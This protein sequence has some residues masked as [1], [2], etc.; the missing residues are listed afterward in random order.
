MNMHLIAYFVVNNRF[1]TIL[2][3]SNNANIWKV[4]VI[5][6]HQ[7]WSEFNII[8]LLY[9]IPISILSI[10]YSDGSYL[11]AMFIIILESKSNKKYYNP[12]LEVPPVATV[13]FLVEEV[14]MTV[15]SLILLLFPWPRGHCFN[16]L[17]LF[18]KENEYM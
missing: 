1:Q 6:L 16:V 3:I 10:F 15:S 7:I 4:Y 14:A 2:E 13:P 11:W 8:V 9:Y 18:W 17:A 12:Y 5:V